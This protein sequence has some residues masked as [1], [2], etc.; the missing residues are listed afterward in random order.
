M[1]QPFFIPLTPL[2]GTPFW[3]DELWDDTGENFRD[4]NFLPSTARPGARR[5]LEWAL[6]TGLRTQWPLARLRSLLARL[7][8]PGRAP[9]AVTLR[10]AARSAWFA[11]PRHGGR[12]A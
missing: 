7:V 3:R 12:P 2:P 10:L 9:A 8:R 5:D 6:L 1:D 4:Y 11:G